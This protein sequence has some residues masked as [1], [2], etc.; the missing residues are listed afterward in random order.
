MSKIQ[1][2]CLYLSLTESR[3]FRIASCF[4]T[5]NFYI[6]FKPCRWISKVLGCFCQ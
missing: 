1:F 3:C 6:F 5:F 2:F 4:N